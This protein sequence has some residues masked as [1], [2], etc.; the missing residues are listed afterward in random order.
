MVAMNQMQTRVRP[1]AS[2]RVA[3]SLVLQAIPLM[4]V[5]FLLFPRVAPLWSIP[6][7]SA[8]STGL[9]DRLTPGDV[10]RLSQ[11]DELAFRAAFDGRVPLQKDLY[12]RGL[13]YSDFA[14]GTWAIAEP[15]PPLAPPT[16]NQIPGA[17]TYD[18]EV[19]LEPTQSKWLFALD[20]PTEYPASA[21]L[22]GDFRLE[23]N[24]P[25]LSVTRYRVSS[26]ADLTMN[27]AGLDPDLRRRETKL[28]AND[29][30]RIR[31]Y[32]RALFAQTGSVE[33]MID[34]M[35]DRI[36]AEPYA[37]TLSPPLLGRRNSIDQFWFD[38]QRGFC[39]HY[40]G[41]T[42]F[43]LR[44]AGI[45]ARMVG[46]YQGGQVNP[47]TGHVVVRQYQ[48]HSW[49]EAWIEGRGWTRFDPTAA[50]APERVESGLNAALSSEDRAVLSFLSSARM[51]GEG[52]LTGALEF[53]DS[54]EHRWNLWVV[55]YD[56]AT[57][58]DVL[59]KLLGKVT[60]AR[61]GIALAIGGGLSLLLVS[62]AL[63][64]RRRPPHRHRLERA[65]DSFCQR[66][67][68][69]GFERA[70]G[71]TPA[72]FMERLSTNTSIDLADLR[73]R[74][75]SS[76]YDPEA[77]SKDE[78]RLLARELRKLRFRLAFATSGQAS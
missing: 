23:N 34:A 32:A 45:P 19:F 13:V 35:L 21:A 58:S 75:Q 24:K 64:W 78:Q 50:V 68:R 43:A 48:A 8:A 20:T 62:V 70:P 71:E 29:N 28:P 36:R 42:V 56:A 72:A 47:V 66:M 40:A 33:G 10:A 54:L 12:W 9:S 76:L 37:Y 49:I 22:L 1:L 14:W 26:N 18:Y 65:F 73:T 7:P 55:G 4:L 41:A 61:I 5:L 63:F 30:P 38:E 2:M 25:V 52:M 57:Q 17:R 77:A 60:P 31:A 6:M 16:R 3:A 11:S 15:L 46:G 27:D 67:A 51:S 39:T 59:K 69:Q 44:A 74:L 53:V